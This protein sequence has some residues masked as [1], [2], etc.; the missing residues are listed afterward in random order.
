MLKEMVD[1]NVMNLVRQK[2]EIIFNVLGVDCLISDAAQAIKVIDPEVL[3]QLHFEV[4][5]GEETLF[6]N[7][8]PLVTFYE[9]KTEQTINGSNVV[10]TFT[11]QYRTY[12]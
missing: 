4:V 3:R 2:D 10:I 7:D 6:L 1:N 5:P 12:K 8:K 9:P 11:Q